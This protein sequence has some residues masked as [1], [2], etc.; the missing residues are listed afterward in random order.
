MDDGA[1]NTPM[2]PFGDQAPSSS[3]G[4]TS[5]FHDLHLDNRGGLPPTLS[6]E[7]VSSGIQNPSSAPVTDATDQILD[8]VNSY[9]PK[10]VIEYHPRALL[11][12]H[13][14]THEEYLQMTAVEKTNSFVDNLN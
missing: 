3:A 9:N 2:P 8:F 12:P 11:D 6:F 7:P 1:T 13:I 5:Q 10:F 14:L 4:L